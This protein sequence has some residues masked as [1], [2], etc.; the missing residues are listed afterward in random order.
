MTPKALGNLRPPLP[1]LAL[2]LNALHSLA[3]LATSPTRPAPADLVVWSSFVQM[4]LGLVI[5]FKS[6]LTDNFCI[7][8]TL[9]ILNGT[10]T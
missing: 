2:L 10:P 4:S 3:S 5:L 7:R 8:S 6:L 9:I 1:T